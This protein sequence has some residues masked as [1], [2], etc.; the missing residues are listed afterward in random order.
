MSSTVLRP[1]RRIDWT[2]WLLV[3][4]VLVFFVLFFVIPLA[5]LLANSVQHWDMATY[6]VIDRFTLFQY[7]RYLFDEFYLGVLFRTLL[8]GLQTTLYCLIAAYPVAIYLTRAGPTER[9]ILTLIIIT[10]LLVSVVVLCLGWMIVVAPTGLINWVL[11]S[12]GW[13]EEPLQL[14]FNENTV[15]A[16]TAQAFFPFVTLA[17]YSSLTNIDPLMVRAARVLG[18]GPLRI[19]WSITLPLS[20]PGALAGS[21]I[22]FALTISSFVTPMML[23]SSWVK[24]VAFLIWEQNMIL[25]DWP[26]GAA[27]AFILLVV[28]A[29]I[30][31][32]YNRLME[33]RLFAGVFHR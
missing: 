21:L 4:P 12:L 1:K 14:Q 11:K 7:E 2:A 5:I 31:V 13:I 3:S 24:M 25:I 17:I 18:A 23:G 26:F 22:V 27:I 8:I 9:S 28:T 20:I 15:I 16:G 30:M 32:S 29:A 33:R 19:F 6:E 10:P